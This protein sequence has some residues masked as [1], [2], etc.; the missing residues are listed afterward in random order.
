MACVEPGGALSP[1]GA[2]ML[3]AM[4]EP[5]TDVEIAALSGRPVFKVRSSM[6][7]LVEA[8]FVTTDGERYSITSKGKDAAKD[9]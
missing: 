9:Q 6:R 4:S 3:K 5:M 8:G 1:S 7:E 2:D